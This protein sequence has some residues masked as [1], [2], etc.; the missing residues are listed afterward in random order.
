MPYSTMCAWDFFFFF[1]C[2]EKGMSHMIMLQFFAIF[3]YVHTSFYD[4]NGICLSYNSRLSVYSINSINKRH[5]TS[6]KEKKKKK[7][8]VSFSVYG[9]QFI[10]IFHQDEQ[11]K[12]Q[13]FPILQ[14]NST[15]ITGQSIYYY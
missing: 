11:H 15:Y 9:S 1:F 5:W 12:Y 10:A 6:L 13:A 7:E 2:S 14:L 8:S 3:H 4:G